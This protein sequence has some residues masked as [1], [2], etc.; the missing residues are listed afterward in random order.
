M[1]NTNDIKD[2][3]INKEK[4][5]PKQIAALVCV[6]LLVAMYVITFIV[7]CLDIADNGK[8]FAACLTA[9]VALPILLWIFIHFGGKKD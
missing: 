1:S 2:T 8:L 4:K 9:T 3:N 7:A 6:A 5:T